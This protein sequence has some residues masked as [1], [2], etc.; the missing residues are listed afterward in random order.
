MNKLHHYTLAVTWTGNTGKGTSAYREYERS[1]TIAVAHKADISGSSDPNFR[2][3]RTKHNPEELFVASLS[4]CHML[5]FLHLCSENGVVVTAYVDQATGTMEETADGGG[6]FIEV[7]LNP[8]V[9]VTEASMIDRAN[10]LHHR[11]NALCFIA[12]SCNFPVHHNPS[13]KTDNG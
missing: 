6:R 9:T 13:C 10:A 4:T 3:D 2:G 12:N 7:T 1:H 8:F 5:W 11:A